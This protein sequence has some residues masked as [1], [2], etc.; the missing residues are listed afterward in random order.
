MRNVEYDISTKSAAS[1]RGK[2]FRRVNFVRIA[3]RQPI[4]EPMK[5]DM[6]KLHKKLSMAMKKADVSNPPLVPP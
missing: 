4:T 6:L 3:V 2:S 1:N 5:N